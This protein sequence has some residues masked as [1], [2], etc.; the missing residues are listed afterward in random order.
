MQ[1]GSWYLLE[2]GS[3]IKFSLHDMGG[4]DDLPLFIN[5]IPNILDLDNAQDLDR[6]KQLQQ[7]MKIL[8]QKLPRDKNG[9]LI[10]DVDEAADIHNNA[11]AMLSRAIGVDVLTTFA[12]VESIDIS[13]TNASEAT[14]QL[15]RVERTVYNALGVS[16][17]LF[18]TDGNLALEK[19]V[20]SDEGSMRHLLLQFRTFFDKLTQNYLEPKLAKKFNFR[21]YMLETTQYNYKELSKMYKEQVQIGYSKM[22]PQIALGHSQSDIVNTAFFENNMLH[23]S[24][25]M[26]PPLMSSTMSSTDVLGNKSQSTSGKNESNVEGNSVGRP[27]KEESEKSDKT[28][29]NEE[30]KN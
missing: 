16:K 24:E 15:E 29:A 20:L 27:E 13:D 6:Q 1:Y 17:N 28:L 3:V 4:D 18:N 30:S 21:L 14:D 19:S 23:L 2:P 10:F 11:V 5:A 12:D 25:I 9:D 26:I 8:V 7:L 22:L